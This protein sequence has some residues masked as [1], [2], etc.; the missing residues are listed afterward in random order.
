[1][2][3]SIRSTYPCPLGA[4]LGWICSRG[5]QGS[6]GGSKW[7]GHKSCERGHL[8]SLRIA[9]S[10]GV[11]FGSH[12]WTRL[13]SRELLSSQCE[14]ELSRLALQKSRDAS[15][16]PRSAFD[17]SPRHV[18]SRWLCTR[19]RPRTSRRIRQPSRR[20]APPGTSSQPYARTRP[21]RLSC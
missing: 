11:S 17:L 9:L 16:H 2:Q 14:P 4:R 21:S 20:S 6:L 1:M 5:L 18:P 10:E 8:N 13:R 3:Q 7:G 12:C 15:K 19:T